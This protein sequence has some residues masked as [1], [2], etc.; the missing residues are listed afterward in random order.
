MIDKRLLIDSVT[1]EKVIERDEWGKEAYGSML[2]LSPVR[3]DR[4]TTLK[5]NEQNAKDE[6]ERKPGV[7]FVYTKFCK[8]AL[9]ESYIGGRL[10]DG[11][12]AY[13]VVGVI[14]ISLFKKQIGYEIEVV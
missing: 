13:R 4:S 11:D 10:T 12:Q 6:I 1:I 8:V 7:V 5:H 2:S 3:F 14:P 9:D